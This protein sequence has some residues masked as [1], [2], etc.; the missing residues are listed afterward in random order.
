[1]NVNKSLLVLVGAALALAFSGLGIVALK[2][3]SASAAGRTYTDKVL[4]GE[5]EEALVNVH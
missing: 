1:M 2:G 3:D 5:D 4:S